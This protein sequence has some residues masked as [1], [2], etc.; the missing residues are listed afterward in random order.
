MM[1]DPDVQTVRVDLGDR[2]YDIKIGGGLIDQLAAQIDSVL[3]G[4]R[5]LIVTDETVAAHQLDRAMASFAPDALPAVLVLP[6]GEPTKSF[7]YL[8]QVVAAILDARLERGDAVVALGGGVIGDLAGFA[9]GIVRRGMALVQVP[10]S[11]LAQVDSSVGGKTGI[12]ASQ[13]KN[14]VGVFHQPALVL[15]DISSLDTLSAREFAAGYAEV[16]KY[17]LIDDPSFFEWLEKNRAALFSG[18]KSAQLRAE[19]IAI[20][21]RAKA[22]VVAADERESGQRALLNLGHTFGHALEGYCKYDGARL[23]HGE[24]V[25]IGMVMAHD[26][27]AR[28]NLASPDDARKVEG[29][30]RSAGLPT[31]LADIPGD[32]PDA[33]T[34]MQFIGQDKKVAR[35]ALT[36]I[37]THGI[38][39]AFVANDVPPSE[40]QTFLTQ[41]CQQA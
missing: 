27:S 21:C 6:A 7:D 32:A 35:G 1:S 30:L 37:L 23:V 19:A 24:A 4:S 28:M 20:S 5:C 25:S 18:P 38:G 26:F 33:E 39:Q 9:A 11:L 29:H 40:V 36:F 13:G 8:Q 3:P 41:I 17:G 22:R 34:L 16:V 31:R 10:T 12:N 2:G 14:L 15:A